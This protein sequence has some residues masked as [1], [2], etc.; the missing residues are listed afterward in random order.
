MLLLNVVCLT[1]ALTMDEE[2]TSEEIRFEAIGSEDKDFPLARKV[3]ED[4]RCS[5]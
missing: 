4:K 1:V 5:V 3:L 2:T